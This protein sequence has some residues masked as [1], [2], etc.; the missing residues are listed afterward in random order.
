M[1]TIPMNETTS[2]V[3]TTIPVN[4]IQ[5]RSGKKVNREKSILITQEEDA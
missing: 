4:E 5:L 3:I 2:Y 1:T